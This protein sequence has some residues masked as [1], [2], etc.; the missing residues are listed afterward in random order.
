MDERVKDVQVW[1]NQT[2]GKVSGFKKAPEN[3]LTGW[4]TI[5]S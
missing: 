4:P 1:L 3:G 2:Y 5:Y